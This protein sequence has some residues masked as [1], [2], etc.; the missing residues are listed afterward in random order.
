MPPRKLASKPKRKVEDEEGAKGAPAVKKDAEQAE[1]S[2]AESDDPKPKKKRAKKDPVTPIHS[3][4]PTNLTVPDPLQPFPRP[5]DGTMRI[6]SFN[7]AGLRA[8]EKKGFSRY[9]IAEDADILVVTETKTA[10]IALEALD[11]RYPFRYWG[12]SAKK[13]Q[14]GTAVF[15]KVEPVNVTYGLPNG[16][17]DVSLAESK[18][19]C[20]TLE[21]A[22]SFVIGTYVPNAG[23]GLKNLP[24]KVAWNRA[25]ERYLRELDA[26]KP[27]IWCGDLNVVP[28]DKDI[29]NW[30]TNYNKSAGC[31]D[32]E[33]NGFNAQ[34]NPSD[35]S[36]HKKLVD[37]WRHLNPDEEGYYTYQSYKFQC[38]SKGIGWRLDYFVVS[39]RVME[40]V[41]ACEMRHEIWGASDHLPLVVDIEG[42]L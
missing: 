12:D 28:T 7:V 9:V 19:R 33:I 15:S 13:G 36:G 42:P 1:Q 40:K 17:E 14:A 32:D 29:R 25:F 2:G 34:L 31:T 35:E 26:K 3:H 30:K 6:S 20:V 10:A 18:G 39:E 8:S 27:V 5:A 41:K 11:D 16:G 37:V 24:D 4:L 23:A 21:F 38:R 22:N